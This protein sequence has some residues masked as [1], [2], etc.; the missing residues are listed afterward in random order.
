M[1]FQG[2]MSRKNSI[3]AAVT[4]AVYRVRNLTQ[5]IKE[6]GPSES[7]ESSNLSAHRT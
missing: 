7:T 2:H 5:L 3:S 1:Q 6:N 4:E